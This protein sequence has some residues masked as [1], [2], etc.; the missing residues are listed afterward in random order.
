MLLLRCKMGVPSTRNLPGR[1]KV[2][3][4]GH[5]LPPPLDRFSRVGTNLINSFPHHVFS[6]SNNGR[7]ETEFGRAVSSLASIFFPSF[8]LYD[9]CSIPSPG[10]FN[11]LSLHHLTTLTLL[12]RFTKDV[13]STLPDKKPSCK[14]RA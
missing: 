14:G 1:K 4:L 5:L 13:Q 10:T 9:S 3:E 6:F 2:A 12:S 8:N 7:W 11:I